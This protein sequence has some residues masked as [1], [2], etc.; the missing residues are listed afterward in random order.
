MLKSMM[1]G[2]HRWRGRVKILCMK[3]HSELQAH[4]NQQVYSKHLK[5]YVQIGLSERG[6]I[7]ALATTVW[8]KNNKPLN[9]CR[10]VEIEPMK[11]L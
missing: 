5:V 11:F 4:S 6:K 1:V 8:T 10:K 2:N 7:Q 3:Y 9:L